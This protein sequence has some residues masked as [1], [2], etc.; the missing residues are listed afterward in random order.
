VCNLDD[1][2]DTAYLA[3]TKPGFTTR[4]VGP[5]NSGQSPMLDVELQRE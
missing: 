4:W 5:V 2:P 1:L 3:V